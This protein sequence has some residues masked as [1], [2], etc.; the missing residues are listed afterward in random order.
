MPE[1]SVVKPC[2]FCGG[3]AVKRWIPQQMAIP[4]VTVGGYAIMCSRCYCVSLRGAKSEEEAIQNW[5][6][7]I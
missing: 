1:K 2:P 7:R 6:T 4:D 5:N 3:Q